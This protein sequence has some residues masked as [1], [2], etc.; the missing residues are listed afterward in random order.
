MNVNPLNVAKKD[1]RRTPEWTGT[2]GD[3]IL[4]M[5][6]EARCSASLHRLLSYHSNHRRCHDLTKFGKHVS[7]TL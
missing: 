1:E 6:R 3:D 4:S 7:V 5:R 2:G